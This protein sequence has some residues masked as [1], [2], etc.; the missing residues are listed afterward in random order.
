MTRQLHVWSLVLALLTSLSNLAACGGCS[1]NAALLTQKISPP[2]SLQPGDLDRDPA[3]D[4]P[5]PPLPGTAIM[6][7]DDAGCDDG[8]D[9]TDN[10]CIEGMCV[11]FGLTND[12]CC[13]VVAL[14]ALGFDESDNVLCEADTPIAGVGWNL[15]TY[16]A[17]SPPSSLYF[18]HP[19]TISMGVGQRVVGA[20][21]LSPVSLP[22]DRLSELTFRLFVDIEADLRHGLAQ[23][24]AFPRHHVSDIAHVQAFQDISV[25]NG[26]AKEQAD[27]I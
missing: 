10:R 5:Q 14:M 3:L 4:A 20:A 24:Q 12:A 11:A 19:E 2:A 22:S 18:G 16:R 8:Q 7:L 15:S 25:N 13:D 27:E 26:Q 1:G 9:C 21:R 23:V 17:T 6:C